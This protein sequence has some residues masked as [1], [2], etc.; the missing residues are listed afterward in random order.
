[1]KQTS[2]KWGIEPVDKGKVKHKNWKEEERK[3]KSVVCPGITL[4]K[5]VLRR[6]YDFTLRTTYVSSQNV[7]LLYVQK[8]LETQNY[9]KLRYFKFSVFPA[10]IFVG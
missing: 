1:M 3:G 8:I 9:Q 7:V 5:K 10:A 6:S 2:E 4:G